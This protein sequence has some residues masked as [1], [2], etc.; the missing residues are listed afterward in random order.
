MSIYK[1][2][3]STLKNNNTY[4]DLDFYSEFFSYLVELVQFFF[5]NFVGRMSIFGATD[6]PV[7]DF[8]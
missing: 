7:L 8:W 1:S 3:M 6:S 4:L 5:F 2:V